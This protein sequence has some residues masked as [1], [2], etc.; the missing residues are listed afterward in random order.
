MI[1]PLFRLHTV[2][3]CRL[4]P[5]AGV[6]A[7]SRGLRIGSLESSPSRDGHCIPPQ[8]RACSTRHTYTRSNKEERPWS[9]C[10][11]VVMRQD[12]NGHGH[13]EAWAEALAR[14]VAHLAAQLTINQIRLRALATEMRE[15]GLIDPESV[16]ARVRTIAEPKRAPTCARISARA[17]LE[18]IDV[19]ALEHDLT[20]YLQSDEG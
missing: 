8:R 10:H 18:V 4:P 5:P 2:V 19:D 9:A 6:R 14:T 16:A 11:L 7:R 1:A 13:D 12:L 17:L 20:E 3:S 15:Q